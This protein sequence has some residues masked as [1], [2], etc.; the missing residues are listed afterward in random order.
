MI[1]KLT[2][3]QKDLLLIYR[4]KWINIGV[5]TVPIDLKKAKTLSDYYYN[6]ILKIKAVPIAVFPSPLTA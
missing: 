6:N 1:T 2:Q 4:N 3:T 5:R